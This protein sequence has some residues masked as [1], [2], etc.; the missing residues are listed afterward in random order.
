VKQREYLKLIEETRKNTSLFEG[1]TGS[2]EDY[3]SLKERY[4][5]LS[6]ENHILFEQVTLLRAHND[7]F[8][9]EVSEKFADAEAKS[10][11]FDSIRLSLELATSERDELVRAN[12]F[13]EQ[14]LSSANQQVMQYEE[15]RRNE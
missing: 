6:E 14:R 10:Q 12:S 15:L 3:N 1:Q 9:R 4:S 13:M 2:S 8:N 5:L 11:R 7:Q